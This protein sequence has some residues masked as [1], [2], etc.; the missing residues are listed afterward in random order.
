MVCRNVGCTCS[1][2]HT[3]ARAPVSNPDETDWGKGMKVDG[4]ILEEK[5]QEGTR[6]GSG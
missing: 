6:E 5:G 4:V 2:Q 1:R 3:P